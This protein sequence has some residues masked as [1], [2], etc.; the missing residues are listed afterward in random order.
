ML[1]H[2]PCSSPGGTKAVSAGG[3]GRAGAEKARALHALPPTHE[4]GRTA[5]ASGWRGRGDRSRAS[6]LRNVLREVSHSGRWRTQTQE[7]LRGC[8]LIIAFFAVL[9]T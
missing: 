7:R 8:L 4:A 1:A 3:A 2:V 6:R 5:K 9:Q